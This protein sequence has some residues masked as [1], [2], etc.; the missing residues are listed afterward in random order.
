M[1]G[2]KILSSMDIQ[3]TKINILILHRTPINYLVM[4]LAVTDM[5]V[6]TFLAPE[7]IFIHTF[8]HP[9]GV[10]GDMLCKL[11]TGGGL[12][13]VGGFA[14]VFTLVTIAIERYYAV[15]HPYENNGKLTNCKL[16]VYLRCYLS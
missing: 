7:V 1:H 9:D 10:T 5:M 8:T 4:N 13:W 3:S 6:A 15:L 14:S 2:T 11:L 16:K 12:A